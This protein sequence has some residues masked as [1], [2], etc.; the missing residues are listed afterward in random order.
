LCRFRHADLLWWF[1]TLMSPPETIEVIDHPMSA[2]NGMALDGGVH[3]KVNAN[4][5]V[6]GCVRMLK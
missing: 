4:E 2:V 5:G 1:Q 6:G 3:V